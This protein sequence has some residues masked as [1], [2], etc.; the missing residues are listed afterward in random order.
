MQRRM[1]EP[2]AAQIKGGWL[3]RGDSVKDRD[4]RAGRASAREEAPA[5][6][7]KAHGGQR[8]EQEERAPRRPALRIDGARA[9]S[10]GG[11]ARAPAPASASVAEDAR[12]VDADGAGLAEVRALVAVAVAV[13]VEP[14]ARLRGG[15]ARRTHHGLG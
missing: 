11:S 10:A 7:S 3:F 1:A 5:P 2:G 15:L 6:P 14:V 13:V 4:T 9:S 8:G 12:S